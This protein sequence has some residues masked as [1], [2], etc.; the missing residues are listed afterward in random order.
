MPRF[1][2]YLVMGV[3]FAIMGLHSRLASGAELPQVR[4]AACGTCTSEDVEGL[5]LKQTNIADL[6]GIKLDVLFLTPPQM[7]AGV[8]SSS[9]DIEWVGPQPTLAQLANGIDI[10]IVAYQYDFELRL[11][12]LPAIRSIADLKDKKIGVPFGTTAYKVA[13]DVVKRNGLPTPSIVNVGAADLGTA[14]VGGQVS[15]VVI[16]DPVWGILEKTYKTGPLEKWFYTGFTNV[17]KAFLETNRNA[18]VRFLAAQM[19]SIVFRANNKAEVDRRYEIVFGVSADVAQAAQVIDR[20]YNWRELEQVKLELQEKDYE[21]LGETKE[22][23]LREKLITK[24]VDIKSSADMSLLS[25]AKQLLKSLDI[26]ASQ[27]TY[28]VPAN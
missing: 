23:L 2:Y 8:A 19:L 15:A 5:I 17:R 26:S 20:S 11:E 9:L 28:V 21:S 14:L 12:A 4:F 1:R 24:N 10:K 7:G 18:A 25:E 16:W 3:I 6:V 13:T 22:Y 27:I